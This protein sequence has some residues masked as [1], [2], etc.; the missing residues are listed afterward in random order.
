MSLTNLHFPFLWTSNYHSFWIHFNFWQDV[1]RVTE[2][3]VD[4]PAAKNPT[5]LRMPRTLMLRW[6]FQ[7]TAQRITLD[8]KL[9][10]PLELSVSGHLSFVPVSHFERLSHYFKLYANSL[11]R[12]MQLTLILSLYL[13]K[14]NNNL[15]T[16]SQVFTG[17]L[18]SDRGLN[19]LTER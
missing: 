1:G 19:I 15:M 18:I 6:L 3:L 7:W 9:C 13:F 12:H 8:G 4:L 5:Q 17:K 2:D 14:T 16:E 10:R 11:T